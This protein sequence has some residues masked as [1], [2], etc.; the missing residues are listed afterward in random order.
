MYIV[1]QDELV[2]FVERARNS[3]VLAIDTE[4]LREKTYYPKLCLI[5]MAT[6]DESVIIDPFTVGDLHVLGSL[7][8]DERIMKIFHAGYQDLE[9]IQYEIG[10]L[11]RP[12]FDTQ[13]AASLLGQTQQIGYASLVHA[14]C[15]VKLRKLDSFTDWTARP[16]SESQLEYAEADVTYLPKMYEVMKESLEKKGRLHWLDDEFAEMSKESTYVCDERERFRK[17]K[18]VM[19]L[20]RRQ[21]AAAREMAAWREIVARKR[22]VPRKWVLTDEQIVEACKREPRKIDDLFMVRGVRERITTRDA[23]TLIELV[24]AALDSSPEA[25]PVV[26]QPVKNEPNVDSQVDLLMSIV[27]M[28]AKEHDIAIHTLASHNDL[29]AIARGHY[30]DVDVLKGWRRELIGNELLELLEGRLTLSIVDGHVNIR[31]KRQRRATGKDGK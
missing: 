18:H 17:L 21:M 31:K 11:P 22:N 28:R 8:E 12:L 7:F 14:I 29:I 4:F 5:Q 30:D 25:W 13:V 23:R 24:V 10:V 20:N 16:L 27:R 19:Q 1:S 6:D 26:A 15:G 9:I 2:A 3:S